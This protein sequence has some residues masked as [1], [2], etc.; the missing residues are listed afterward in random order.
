MR[1]EDLNKMRIFFQEKPE[2]GSSASIAKGR[3]SIVLA[4][5]ISKHRKQT[6]RRAAKQLRDMAAKFDMLA[7][8]IRP[9]SLATLRRINAR[10]VI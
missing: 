5:T 3:T 4:N 10:K 9:S 2:G 8:E 1:I 7:E 6:I